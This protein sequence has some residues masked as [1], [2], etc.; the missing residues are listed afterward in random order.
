MT[1]DG[2]IFSFD[3]AIQTKDLSPLFAQTDWAAGRTAED[4]SDALQQTQLKLGAWHEDVLVG[5]ARVLT[6]DHFRALIDDVVV[7]SLWR[8][9]GI[10]QQ[11]M[12]TLAARLDHV[13][14]IFLRCDPE[15]VSYY[16]S[17]GYRQTAV[18]LD[19]VRAPSTQLASPSH[20][21]SG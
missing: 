21:E 12:R 20:I 10:G 17:L 2:I 3:R 4:L 14:E 7:H 6:D 8:R 11:I 1:G 16:A 15:L 5:F 13:E 19:L 18:C 9:R